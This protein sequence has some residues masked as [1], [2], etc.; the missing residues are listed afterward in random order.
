MSTRLKFLFV[1]MAILG[2]FL[3]LQLNNAMAGADPTGNCDPEWGCPPGATAPYTMQ[4]MGSFVGGVWVWADDFVQAADGQFQDANPDWQVDWAPHITE[5]GF[6]TDMY[7]MKRAF[8]S[9]AS[10]SRVQVHAFSGGAE[11]KIPVIWGAGCMAQECTGDP[12]FPECFGVEIP[13]PEEYDPDIQYNF[14]MACDPCGTGADLVNFETVESTP[15]ESI[16]VQSVVWDGVSAVQVP[17]ARTPVYNMMKYNMGASKIWESVAIFE[18]ESVTY[19]EF[20]GK[21]P[22]A[23]GPTTFTITLVDGTTHE[24]VVNV[25]SIDDLPTI[26]SKVYFEELVCAEKKLDKC[27]PEK[28]GKKKK[29][30]KKIKATLESGEVD[31]VSIRE[32]PDPDGTGNALILQWPE[33][34]GALFGG[35]YRNG[36]TYQLR[37]LVWKEDLSKNF[38]RSLFIDCP[39]QIGTVVIDAENYNWLKDELTAAGVSLDDI[40]VTF[41]YRT[42]S[43]D[44]SYYNRGY[45]DPISFNA[46]P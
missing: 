29:R 18:D 36:E 33:P 4:D 41:M 37:V 42:I 28:S 6:R 22:T 25:T 5:G 46:V 38:E 11:T 40:Q 35:K 21:I 24:H 20:L 19:W 10:E 44:Y 16:D 8:V 7:L 31:N 26:P 15:E 39:A 3:T 9:K 12:E 14:M 13:C 27:T 43:P 45:S 30:G 17:Y 1:T 32:V 34:D 23:V 2:V